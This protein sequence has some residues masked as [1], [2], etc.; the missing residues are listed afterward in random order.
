MLQELRDGIVIGV[1]NFVA[2]PNGWYVQFQIA[3]EDE[4]DGFLP[5]VGPVESI[6]SATTE[7][8]RT[9][10]LASRE[11]A[12]SVLASVEAGRTYRV[13]LTPAS[14]IVVP[15]DGSPVL[16]PAT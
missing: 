16:R 2:D 5:G 11:Q 9:Q 14:A 8:L 4:Y 10:R 7:V 15:A 6:R 1:D 13:D 12:E 3:V